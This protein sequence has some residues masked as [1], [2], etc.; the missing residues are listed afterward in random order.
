MTSGFRNGVDAF[1]AER[2]LAVE[3]FDRR[4]RKDDVAA[5]RRRRFAG[6]EGVCLIGTAQEKSNAFKGHKL[7]DER[8]A[9][10]RFEYSRQ[11]V[12]VIQC[13]FYLVDSTSGR[14][15]SRSGPML[16]SRSASA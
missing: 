13:Y 12:C 8:T 5:E 16:P 14:R 15:S 1:A 6:H 9:R 11:T 4:A 10:V 3:R 7:R 2:G